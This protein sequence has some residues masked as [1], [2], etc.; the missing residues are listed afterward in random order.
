VKYDV[1]VIG[2]GI[3]GQVTANYLARAGKNVLMLEQ[4]HHAGGNMSGFTRKG[5]YF[6]GG[7]QSFESLG[8]VLPILRDLIGVGPKDFHKAHYRMVSDDFDFFIESPEQVEAE[9]RNAFPNEPGITPLF[10]EIKEVSRFLT[11]NYDPWN[12]PLVNQTGARSVGRMLPW[13]ARLKKWSTFRYREKACSLIQDPK[14]RTWFTQIGYYRMPYLF[15]AGFWHLWSY[16][17]WY[18][19]GGM[20]AMH[21]RLTEAFEA[22]GGTVKFNTTVTE[23]EVDGVRGA[24]RG[25]ITADG[26]RYEA[27]EIVYAGDYKRLLNQLLPAGTFSSKL[28]KRANE[29][30]LTEEIL[31]VYLGLSASDDELATVLGG[32]NH[33]FYFP[34][35]D[36]IFPDPSS[37][38]DV[39]ANMWVALNHFGT[40][41]T[42]APP[43]KSTLTLQTY[44]SFSW[45][46]FWHNGSASHKRSAAYK[47]FKNEVG[48]ELVGLA[49][50][51]IPGLRDQ[52]EYMEVGTPLSSERFSLNTDGSTGGW[53]YDDQKSFVWRFPNLN[54]IK[55]PVSNLKCAGHY[56]LWP[57]GVISATLC[58]RLVANMLLDK[59]PLSHLDVA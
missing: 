6:D 37:P 47:A 44:S 29:A 14:L 40:E 46:N 45:Q 3:A 39:H 7:D 15:L 11:E 4:N 26:E 54:R 50:N 33:P 10:A 17:Y 21:D 48:M 42:S 27:D 13:L 32:A 1:V 35:Y 52:I 59:N 57:G 31:G 12:F 9:L 19:I 43:G 30:E 36:V 22:H 55:T 51:L 49:E 8:I 18:P 25:V 23:I 41:S 34:N 28:V 16:D 58:G 2:A 53:C 20:Q 5:F 38:R 56:A 24:A